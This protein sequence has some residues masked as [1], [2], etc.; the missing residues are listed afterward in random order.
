MTSIPET[1]K[2]IW[3]NCIFDPSTFSIMRL[4]FLKNFNYNFNP[5]TFSIVIFD[6]LNVITKP[7]KKI[8]IFW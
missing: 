2:K 4:W 1:V 6:N 7:P 5:S 8:V 3:I